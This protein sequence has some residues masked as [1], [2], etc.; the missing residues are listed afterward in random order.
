MRILTVLIVACLFGSFLRA[1]RPNILIIFTDDQGFYD[2]SYYNE[3][4]DI[5]TP[6]IDALAEAG[7]RFDNF[8]ANC[9]VCSPS[10]AALL[11]GRQQ[12]LVGVPGV[13]RDRVENSWG[14]WDPNSTSIATVLSKNGYDTAL[15]GKWHLGLES[16][17]LPNDRGFKFFK[18]FI[19]DMMDDYYHHRRNDHNFMRRNFVEIDPE[20]HATDLFSQ[21]AVD[22][23]DEASKNEDP[24][25]LYLAYN[26]PHSP[27]QPPEEW[28][29]KV[30]KREPGIADLRARFV[31]LTEHMDY[32]I[33]LVVQ[34]LK[35]NGV[36]DDTI[37]FFTSDNGGSLRFGSDNGPLRD[38]KGTVYEGG[39]R[40]PAAVV[41]N[42]TIQSG[43]VSNHTA[44]TM[45]IFPTIMDVC[46]IEWDG[47]LD[48][49][50]F[51]PVLTG[52]AVDVSER[53]MIFSRRE[54]GLAYNGKTIEAI[55]IGDF[56]LVHNSPYEPYE[57]YNIAKDP[58]EKN[59]L[60]EG[61]S[62]N[63]YSKVPHFTEL[64]S[65]LA[66]HFQQRGRVPWQGPRE[67]VKP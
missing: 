43:S 20:G 4:K 17:N 31:A 42:K 38:Q 39:L 45:D 21:W 65:R 25:F 19:G 34:S 2:V 54:G 41:W 62:Q 50:S 11:T 24:F 53:A 44:M 26:A 6:A 64:R 13:I 49:V 37:I 52:G 29:E 15:V 36:Y 40:V 28:V 57:M 10:R 7:M 48:G 9:P 1:E 32:G 58:Y 8:Y 35:D 18:G 47:P 46:G 16:P 59:N 14:Y 12:D 22:Y 33:G 30:K 67:G 61:K 63:E 23:I 51:A 60:L 27:I 55:R 56:K 5:E 3:K 66:L